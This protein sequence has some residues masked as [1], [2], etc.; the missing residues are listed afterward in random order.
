MNAK[1]QPLSWAEVAKNH[2]P[3]KSGNACRKRFER[4]M[5]KHRGEEWEGEK[6]EMLATEYREIR[7]D[8]WQM[9]ANRVGEKWETV[10][11]KVSMLPDHNGTY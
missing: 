11:V 4:L 6:L 2:F 8:M 3:D 1:A 5:E 7:A 10:E 9:L